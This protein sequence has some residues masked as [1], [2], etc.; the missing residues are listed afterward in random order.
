M[1]GPVRRAVRSEFR[2][3]ADAEPPAGAH[4]SRPGLQAVPAKP[5][6]WPP[7]RWLSR[8]DAALAA[9]RRSSWSPNGADATLESYPTWERS[10]VS[11]SCR[12]G[13]DTDHVQARA[14]RRPSRPVRTPLRDR[15]AVPP[16]AQGARAAEEPPGD[17]PRVRIA[18]GRRATGAGHRRSRSLRGIRRAGISC[19]RPSTGSL[20]GSGSGWSLTGYVSE[21]EKVALLSGAEALVYP[22]LYEGF[23]LPVIEAMACGTPVLT[24]NISA[25]PETAGDAALLVDSD[26]LRGDRGRPGAPAD[27]QA[28]RGRSG[29][30]ARRGRARS[31]GRTTARQTADICASQGVTGAARCV[32]AARGALHLARSADALRSSVRCRT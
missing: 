19:G 23:G 16:V 21:D 3:A 30:R 32:A 17:D 26:D 14:A 24:S 29:S 9:R 4:R 7:R 18:P 25:L 12:S 11:R 20:P 2:P 10:R 27:G 1:D 28:L 6:R 15:G 5:P 31:P 13:V 8:L 22:S